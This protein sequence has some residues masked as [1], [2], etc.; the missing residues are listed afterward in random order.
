[1]GSYIQPEQVLR[2]DPDSFLEKNVLD[3]FSLKDRTVVITGGARGIGLALAFA[4]A[5]VGGNVAIIDAAAEP[6][7]HFQV[8]KDRH[9]V[10]VEH[11][12]SDVTKYDTLEATFNKIVADFGSI[13]GL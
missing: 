12:Q 10:K 3:L 6:H 1:M 5:E 13:D 2:R 11:Y 8:L 4:V 7:K 9:Q